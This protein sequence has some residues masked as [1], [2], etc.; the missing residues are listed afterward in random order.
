MI[1]V[2]SIAE[3]S[4]L[5]VANLTGSSRVRFSKNWRSWLGEKMVADRMTRQRGGETMN[6]S[7]DRTL[8]W[9]LRS[10]AARENVSTCRLASFPTRNMVH[11]TSGP[12][13]PDS[14]DT[15]REKVNRNG[16]RRKK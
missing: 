6:L 2:F 5:V 3:N 11:N 14:H 8:R 15:S 7:E 16:G 13:Q 12:D 10:P 4:A 9:R 1:P